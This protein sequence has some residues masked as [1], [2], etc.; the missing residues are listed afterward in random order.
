MNLW[1]KKVKPDY[2]KKEREKERKR[3][4]KAFEKHTQMNKDFR[5]VI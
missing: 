2:A 5:E 3:K 4:K 1:L